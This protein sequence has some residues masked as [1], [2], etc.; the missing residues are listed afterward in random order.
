MQIRLFFIAA[1]ILLFFSN[2]LAFDGEDK[3]I[4][5][6]INSA[7]I[8]A[9][10]STSSFSNAVP[11]QSVANEIISSNKTVTLQPA[12]T[13]STN[14][15]IPETLP[16]KQISEKVNPPTNA[17]TELKEALKSEEIEL[18]KSESKIDL[19]GSVEI[20]FA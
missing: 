8:I 7:V 16:R 6:G 19:L 18:R 3:A 4:F 20:S 10:N 1:Q 13:Q 9:E 12:I 5:N 11:L 2:S 17:E 15:N 14:F